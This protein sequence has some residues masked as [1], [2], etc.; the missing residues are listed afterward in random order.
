MRVAVVDIGSNS[1]RVLIADIENGRV[2]DELERRSMV[3][4]LGAGVD[5][6][7][8]LSEEAM[9]IVRP[10]ASSRPAVRP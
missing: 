6:D 9:Q 3:T 4:R 10:R 1:T 5:S 8:H 2:V 7:G